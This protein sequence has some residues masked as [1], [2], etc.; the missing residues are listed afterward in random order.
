MK[1]LVLTLA[2]LTTAACAHGGVSAPAAA[3]AVTAAGEA[4]LDM[5]SGRTMVAGT[6]NDEDAR[7]VFD[8]GAGGIMLMKSFATKIGVQAMGKAL[9]GSP[10]GGKPVEAELTKLASLKVGGL[11]AANLDAILLDDAV[12]PIPGVD[13]VFGP[14]QYPDKVIAFDLAANRV[15]FLTE[16][17]A[18]VTSWH[19]L[20]A[21]GMLT[22]KIDIGGKTVDVHIDTGNPGGLVLPAAFAK[23]LE[24]KGPL[25]DG[26]PI[27]TV[28]GAKPVKI[29]DLNRPGTLAGSPVNIV[30]ARFID[31]PMGN[32]GS[33]FLKGF[34]IVIDVPNRRWGLTGTQAPQTAGAE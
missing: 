24:L 17:P 33:A 12:M 30:E 26:K 32:A 22:G 6:V 29:A 31:T 4:A 7:L 8:T 34:T 1:S 20:D 5:S 23:E 16:T 18:E 3:P 10:H 2:L 21:H 15:R 28:D 19:P 25:R 11:E 14:R 13:G 27:R 9:M